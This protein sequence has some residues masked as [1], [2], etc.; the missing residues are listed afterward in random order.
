VE[1]KNT[2]VLLVKVTAV[3]R[4]TAR[5]REG[6]KTT[7][8]VSQL[9]VG[10][11]NR[12]VMLSNGTSKLQGGDVESEASGLMES[13]RK[14]LYRLSG[15]QGGE[16]HSKLDLHTAKDLSSPSLRNTPIPIVTEVEHVLLTGHNVG[17]LCLIRRRSTICPGGRLD[18]T[19]R[20]R[21]A[22]RVASEMYPQ[23]QTVKTHTK[24]R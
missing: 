17:C 14:L 11:V 7:P 2:V 18:K 22:R 16:I 21:R 23:L 13:H 10:G 5:R 1:A 19:N 9:T 20:D 15:R 4:P 12:G 24:H 3:T 6:V 8:H